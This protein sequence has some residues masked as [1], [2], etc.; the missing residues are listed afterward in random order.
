MIDTAKVH[1]KNGLRQLQWH[2]LITKLRFLSAQN[3][4]KKK[5][6]TMQHWRQQLLATF[7]NL[8]PNLNECLSKHSELGS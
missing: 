5:S 7:K 8:G 4:S 2:W 3:T 1:F 6:Q